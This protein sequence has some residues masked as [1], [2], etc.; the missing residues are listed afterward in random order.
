[1][2]DRCHYI[3]YTIYDVERACGCHSCEHVPVYDKGGNN[4]KKFKSREAA[5]EAGLKAMRERKDD[6][7]KVLKVSE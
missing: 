1:M 3:A 4:Y 6:R 2:K 5:D 7:Y